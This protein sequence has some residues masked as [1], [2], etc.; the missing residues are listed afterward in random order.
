MKTVA[1][2]LISKVLIMIGKLVHRGTVKAGEIA[3]KLDSKIFTKLSRPS[4][5]IAV[6]GSSGKGSTTKLIAQVLRSQGYK[7]IHNSSG[8]NLR[9]GILT[10]MLDKCTLTGKVNYDI[11]V[12][13]MDERWAK[14]VFP[15]L[16]PDYVVITNLTRDQ[17]PRQGNVDIVFEDIKKA[18]K[19]DMHLIINADDPYLLKFVG[20]EYKKV[21]YFGIA[22]NKYSYTKNKFENL[23]LYYCPKC[24]SKLV[25]SFYHFETLGNYSCPNCD[26]HRLPVDYE[27][28][29]VNYDDKKIV[30]NRDYNIS[31]DMP[32]LFC[33]Y[34]IAASFATLSLIGLDK[35]VISEQVSKNTSDNKIFNHFDI[36]NREV[37][38]FNNKN[39]NSTT[40]NQ[41][42]LFLERIHKPKTIVIGWKE[43]SRRYK[44]NDISWLYDIDFELLTKHK[45]DKVV[46]VGRDCYD[47]ATRMKLAGFKNSKIVNFENLEDAT[48]FLKTKTKNDIY[49]ILNFDYVDPFYELIKEER[50]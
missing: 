30:I 6:T 23:N 5:I 47:I 41:T 19:P 43:I 24:G 29:D 34:N 50:S 48:K 18:L 26:F 37:Y 4:K 20:K 8:S 25:Y 31:L 2:I 39:E 10:T 32:I 9:S 13:E 33:A 1:I 21:T 38:I 22:K 15:E 27:V 7:V 16:N 3:Y 40:F 35:Q 14:I 17:P 44:F 49:A 12:V 28:T 11:F 46:C 42:L 36:T 45:I